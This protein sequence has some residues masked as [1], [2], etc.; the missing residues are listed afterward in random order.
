[1]ELVSV[2]V[3]LQAVVLEQERLLSESADSVKESSG[4]LVRKHSVELEDAERRRTE[5]LAMLEE[6]TVKISRATERI[7]TL[8]AEVKRSVQEVEDAKLY[9]KQLSDEKSFVDAN[10]R[11]LEEDLAR[12]KDLVCH[13]KEEELV[14]VEGEMRRMKEE[15]EKERSQVDVLRLLREKEKSD[16]HGDISRLTDEATKQRAEAERDLQ[17]VRGECAQLREVISREKQAGVAAGAEIRRLSKEIARV[18]SLIDTLEAEVERVKIDNARLEVVVDSLSTE[19]ETERKQAD[20]AF[21]E[22]VRL[23]DEVRL[24]RD[25]GERVGAEKSR[26]D[27]EL[28][29]SQR[30][31]EE[32][33][34]LVERNQAHARQLQIDLHRYYRHN[35]NNNNSLFISN[36]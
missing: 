13:L 3:H 16:A 25:E 7:E 6:Q 23:E 1:M 27:G 11:L 8:E 2:N 29:V 4:V 28:G 17:S 14:R 24:V 5:A 9:G 12:H 33:K 18:T 30:D 19:L 15:L 36:I 22:C 21:K 34:E 26:V 20:E 31:V 35:N 32:L 10:L